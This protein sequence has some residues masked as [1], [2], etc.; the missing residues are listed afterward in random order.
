MVLDLKIRARAYR[1]KRDA[2]AATEPASPVLLQ[3]RRHA[4]GEDS[5]FV[6]PVAFPKGLRMDAITPL[7]RPSLSPLAVH[8]AGYRVA[9]KY[10]RLPLRKHSRTGLRCVVDEVVAD[11][12]TAAF[13][14]RAALLMLIAGAAVAKWTPAESTHDD[15]Q[16][17]ELLYSRMWRINETGGFARS[18]WNEF[19]I[20]INKLHSDAFN[21][22]V[23]H[24]VEIA[25]VASKLNGNLTDD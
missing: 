13:C 17:R 5:H 1:I 21:F 6:S 22:V 3:A 24:Q 8:E 19:H 20:L 11:D 25:K 4:T 15:A 12:G 16:A 2:L 14:E 10:L 23:Q 7:S 9:S 18:E